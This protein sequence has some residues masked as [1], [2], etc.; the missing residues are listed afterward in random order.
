MD[1]YDY[2]EEKNILRILYFL[3]FRSDPEPDPHQADAYTQ[4]SDPDPH[5][6]DASPHHCLNYYT[7]TSQRVVCL[8]LRN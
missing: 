7:S 5:Q 3:D 8:V 1:H 6:T 2:N 4:D